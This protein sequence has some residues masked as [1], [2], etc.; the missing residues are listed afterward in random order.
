MFLPQLEPGDIGSAQAVI[1][2]VAKQ[3]RASRARP[4]IASL[5]S[6]APIISSGSRFADARVHGHTD[7]P[8]GRILLDGSGT[9]PLDHRFCRRLSIDTGHGLR[10]VAHPHRHPDPRIIRW[11]PMLDIRR[12]ERETAIRQIEAEFDFDATQRLR[13][14]ERLRRLSVE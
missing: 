13:N 1:A 14:E 6:Q 10:D 8:L 2:S 9:G 4:W 11:R 12:H 3:S 5:R 7:D